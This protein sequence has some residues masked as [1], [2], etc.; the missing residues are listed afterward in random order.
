MGVAEAGYSL[1]SQSGPVQP[2]PGGLSGGSGYSFPG[3]NGS[4]H[5]YPL[6]FT[7]SFVEIIQTSFSL[8]RLIHHAPV[9]E[10]VIAV[11]DI[12]RVTFRR[13]CSRVNFSGPIV[14]NIDYLFAQPCGRNNLYPL[15]YP[16]HAETWVCKPVDS[17]CFR[18]YFKRV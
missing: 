14:V 12:P 18:Q 11:Q 8:A 4:G 15:S 7:D 9:F 13:I 6:L 5:M 3:I 2:P 17:N 10:L 16:L 1:G